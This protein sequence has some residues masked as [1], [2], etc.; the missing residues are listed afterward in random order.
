MISVVMPAYNVEFFISE[1]IISVQKQTYK[2][3]E[4]IIINDGSTDN[5]VSIVEPFLIDPRIKLINQSNAGVSISRNIGIDMAKGEYITFL[6]SDDLWDHE[7][8]A[9]MYQGIVSKQCD[10]IYSGYEEFYEDGTTRINK[11]PLI[12]G[13]IFDCVF[14]GKGFLFPFH[15][16]SILI[17]KNLV[18][19]YEIRFTEKRS[20]AEDHE[21]ILKLLCITNV[22]GVNKIFMHY[23]QRTGSVT[24]R[25]WAVDF[26]VQEIYAYQEVKIFLFTFAS[27]VLIEKI[28]SLV[29]QV[30]D[31]KIYR[32]IWKAIK[33][34]YIEEA[35]FYIGKWN[36]ELRRFYKSTS[37]K[38]KD[39][40]KCWV[41]LSKNR[42]L[43]KFLS[44]M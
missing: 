25:A 15:L 44:H 38:V 27:P 36:A 16:G 20:Y 41:L 23:R 42:N 9:Q 34:G 26:F 3:W 32:F 22:F 28:H 2:D 7:F 21:F 13:N 4:L 5:T 29:E 31:Y 8:L 33:N 14:L 35:L 39:R 1:S 43:L 24:K 12:E 30:I 37:G 6:D 40:L 10:V 18:D 11:V 19:L 17:R